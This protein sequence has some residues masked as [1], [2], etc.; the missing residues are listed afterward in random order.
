M[1]D[2][3]CDVLT[4]AFPDLWY[5]IQLYLKKRLYPLSEVNKKEKVCFILLIEYS[6]DRK[7]S[8]ELIH[9]KDLNF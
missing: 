2:Q 7:K 4:T 1:A 5:L 3:A 9:I 8:I 6:R